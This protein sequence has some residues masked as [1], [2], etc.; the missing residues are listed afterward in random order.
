VKSSLYDAINEA[1]PDS[2][3][4]EEQR[5][6]MI[7]DLADNIYGWVIDFYLDLWEGDR[8]SVLYERLTSP[9]GDVR[10]G[11]VLAAKIGTRGV[12]KAAY[13][14]TGERGANTYYDDEGLS[15]K[16]SF[17]IRPVE[18]AR[19]SSRFSASRFHPI[20]KR[21]RPH[22]GTDYAARAGTP[23]QATNDGTVTRAGR[24]GTYGIMVSIRHTQGI[25]TRYAHMSRLASGIKPGVRVEQGR[26]I[27][28]VGMTGLASAP[29]VHYEILKNGKFRDPRDLLE[30]QPGEP[31][32]AERTG[33][34]HNIMAQYNAL[35][36]ARQPQ[37]TAAG[38]DN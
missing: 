10:Y 35:L 34:F 18:F 3:L 24:W 1:I 36:S 23:I 8:F 21:R 5:Y 19:L 4:P 2:V 26:V 6:Y 16:R 38:P 11:R 30:T 15:L 28:Y 9:L 20:L 17:K 12:E 33:E 37:V 13:V 25:E 31:V 27:G 32:P 7:Y 14:M 22:N 29:H